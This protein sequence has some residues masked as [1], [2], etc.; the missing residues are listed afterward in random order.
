MGFLKNCI[1]ALRL[2]TIPLS[3]SGVMLGCLL[4]AADFHVSPVVAVSVMLTAALLQVISNVSNELGDFLRGAVSGHGRSASDA[5]RSGEMTSGSLKMILRVV[6]V[7]TVLSGLL[8]IRLSFG[9]VFSL[10]AFVMM[11]FGY[12]SIRAAMKYTLG[13]NPY[14][15]RGLGDLYV[16]VFF[17]LVSVLGAYFVCTH[18][19]GTVK[20]VLPAVS[21]GALSMA[22][23]NV[24][25]IRDMERDRD[26][27]VT[28]AGKLGERGAKIYQTVLVAAGW[29][30][31][32][33]YVMLC[34][35]DPWH[36]L[37][38]LSL[39][40]FILHLAGIWKKPAGELD[41]YLPQLVI[42]TFAFCLLAGSGFL[43]YLI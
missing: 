12:F 30:S 1:S 25:N 10:D 11:I 21:V 14:G 23:L 6:I 19:F 7:L 16:F 39:P 13:K 24:N 41:G 29:I 33:A 22:V 40:L 2:R 9:T 4:A 20:L 17:G 43:V 5:L 31:M 42:S 28:V 37:Y 36:Y 3:L 35:F 34:F 38:V 32:T 15:Y 18:T 26:M 8:M 27:R